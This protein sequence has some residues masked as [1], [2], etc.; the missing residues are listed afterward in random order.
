MTRARILTAGLFLMLA[1]CYPA[2]E[3]PP[4]YGP[5]PDAYEGIVKTWL[6]GHVYNAPTI[7]DVTVTKPEQGKIWVGNLYGGFAYGW[8]TCVSYD[9]RDRDG[10]YKGAQPYTALIKDGAVAHAGVYDLVNAGC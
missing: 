3:N 9:V 8:K 4:D 10:R 2:P 1:G 7:K 6:A 5:F